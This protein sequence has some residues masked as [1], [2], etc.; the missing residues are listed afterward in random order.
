MFRAAFVEAMIHSHSQ[1]R[2]HRH[3]LIQSNRHTTLH[4]T[5]AAAG[6][7]FPPASLTGVW[8]ATPS[9]ATSTDGDNTPL[10][11]LAYACKWLLFAFCFYLVFFVWLRTH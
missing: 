1:R 8:T 7:S 9:S 3:S 11:D 10:T 6:L 2:I 4:R 5:T